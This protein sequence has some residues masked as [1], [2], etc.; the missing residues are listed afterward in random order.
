MNQKTTTTNHLVAIDIARTPCKFR[1]SRK[2]SVLTMMKLACAACS[3]S[4]AACRIPSWSAKP[5][6]VTSGL[7]WPRSTRRALPC[8]WSIPARL[9]AFALSEGIKAKTDPIDARMILRFA[10]EKHLQPTP[11]PEPAR[12]ELAALLDRRSHL[13]EQ[14]GQGEKPPSEKPEE[15]PRL[16]P[17]LDQVPRKGK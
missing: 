7:Y 17:A 1:A 11:P 3:S 12:Q 5:P 14:P 4:L 6:A 16:H 2:A 10:Q 15:H 9:R 13:S 8:A